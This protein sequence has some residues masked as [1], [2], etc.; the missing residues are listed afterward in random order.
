MSVQGFYLSSIES[1]IDDVFEKFAVSLDSIR[2]KFGKRDLPHQLE[3]LESVRVA[4]L[5]KLKS[6]L[7]SMLQ[8][9]NQSKALIPE[10]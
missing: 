6:K 4:L 8:R 7:K 5:I 9:D 10:V 3:V 1:S 2:V